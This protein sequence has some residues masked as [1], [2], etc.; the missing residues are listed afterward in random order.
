M[1]MGPQ[2]GGGISAAHTM[3]V[4][5]H[6]NHN[7]VGQEIGTT[8]AVPCAALHQA[9]DRVRGVSVVAG[10]SPNFKANRN[11]LK[12]VCENKENRSASQ[13]TTTMRDHE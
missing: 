1:A 10:P 12:R 5:G 9:Q 7:C 4:P 11:L 2:M 3:W 13:G 6:K 8:P